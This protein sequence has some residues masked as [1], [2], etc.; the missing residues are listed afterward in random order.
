MFSPVSPSFFYIKV[1]FKGLFFPDENVLYCLKSLLNCTFILRG[2]WV[3]DFKFG[4]TISVLSIPTLPQF[5]HHA[6]LQ[7]NAKLH[8]V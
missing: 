8:P 2:V 1:G 3:W 6:S 4:C 7:S 5:W